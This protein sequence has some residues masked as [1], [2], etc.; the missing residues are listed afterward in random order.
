MKDDNAMRLVLLTLLA[1][2]L[3]A[4]AQTS[5]GNV[6]RD[7]QNVRAWV[8]RWNALG[9]DNASA[10]DELLTLYAPDAL[11][12]TGPSPHQRGTAT[13]RGH[14]GIRVLASRVA[15]SRQRLTYR[16]E[17]ETANEQTAEL[18]HLAAGPWKGPSI[19]IQMMAVYT[20]REGGKRWVVPGAAFFQ[21]I[22]GKIRRAR[23]YYAEA[24][25]AEVEPEPR[26]RPP[27]D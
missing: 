9:S 18:M 6:D 8:Q 12:I 14:D 16:I 19:A 15:A 25:K 2:P 21:L 4:A 11:H 24:E 10:V 3:A 5:A 7:E 23:I 17:T 13:Y 1:V 26:R 20:D 22:D 27:G